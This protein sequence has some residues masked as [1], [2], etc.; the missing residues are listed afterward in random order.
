MEEIQYQ[1]SAIQ[2]DFPSD[3][4]NSEV[5][6]L[7][8]QLKGVVVAQLAQLSALMVAADCNYDFVVEFIDKQCLVHAVS[9]ENRRDVI[10][11]VTNSVL[12]ALFDKF[13]LDARALDAHASPLAASRK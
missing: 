2:R 1:Q 3:A 7:E 5:E 11:N 13:P 6:E 4:S 10:A 9:E 8:R 12:V